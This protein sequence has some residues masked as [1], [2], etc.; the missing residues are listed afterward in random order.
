LCKATCKGFLVPKKKEKERK[1]GTPNLG[2]KVGSRKIRAK[3]WKVK[4]IGR[5][6]KL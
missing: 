5:V 1:K 2:K 3:P 4:K 6:S